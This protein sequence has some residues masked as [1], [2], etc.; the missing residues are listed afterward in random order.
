MKIMKGSPDGD[1]AT[2]NGGKE[3]SKED[4]DGVI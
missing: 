2:R 1:I 4:L 3:E